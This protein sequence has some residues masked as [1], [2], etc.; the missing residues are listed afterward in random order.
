MSPFRKIFDAFARPFGARNEYG[1]RRGASRRH[2]RVA[3][4]RLGGCEQL[5]PK[6]VMAANLLAPIVVEQPL[7]SDSPVTI[8][9]ANHFGESAVTGTVV[10]FDTNAP[11][12]NPD[13]FVEL[14]DEE[15]AGRTRT[16]PL[17]VAN[18]LSYVN[19]PD[20]L[21][22]YDETIVHRA[23]PGFVI[24]GGGY[25][26]PDRAANLVGSDPVAVP[27]KPAIT[28]EPGNLN[29]RGTIAMAKLPNLPNSATNQFFFN[30]V[31]NTSLNTDNGGFTAFGRVLGS[32]MTVIDTMASALNYDAT[33]YYGNQ[34]FDDLPL[35]NVNSD[36]IVQPNDFVKFEDVSVVNETALMSFTVTSANTSKLTASIVN[37][38][39]V[40][41][42]VAGQTGTVN[43]TVTGRS[44]LDNSTASGTF[45]VALG[46]PDTLIP[47]ESV[48]NV[49]LSKGS[50]SNDIYVNG[51]T[52]VYSY[53]GQ[54]LDADA[55]AG[56]YTIERAER[57]NG[58][59]QL[60]LRF[61]DGKPWVWT[62][63][64]DWR[65]ASTPATATALGTD[66]F[67]DA[68]LAF[69]IDL[70]LDG[71][72]G[73]VVEASG[74]TVL[75]RDSGGR[76]YAAGSPVRLG[77]THITADVY[78]NYGYTIIA[79]EVIGGVN[80]LLLRHS[81]GFLWTWQMDSSW[82][83]V[84]PDPV[85]RKGMAAFFTAEST[86]GI[87]ADGDGHQGLPPLTTVEATGTVLQRDASGKLYVNG[88]G[89]LMGT[90]HITAG[91]YA[92]FGYSVVA[93]ETVS[94]VN[95]LLL[96]RG[97]DAWVWTFDTNWVQTAA[98]PVHRNGT[99]G[100]FTAERQF[101][102]DI[103]GDGDTG[104]PTLEVVESKG[105]FTLMADRAGGLYVNNTPLFMADGATRI[106]RD[107]Y[108]SY[109]YTIVAA[110]LVRTTGSTFVF[111]LLLQR[112][113]GA[114]WA[115]TMDARYR[116][117]SFGA[118][119]S[120]GSTAFFDL[121][122]LF[123]F[124]GNADGLAGRPH[125]VAGTVQLTKDS[126]DRLYVD[127]REVRVSSV[128]LTVGFYST[129][130]YTVVA[131]ER[132]GG[133]NRVLLRHTSGRLWSWTL[134]DFWVV[135]TMPATQ[136]NVGTSGFYDAEQQFG[137]DADM[138]GF[139]GLPAFFDVEANG[140]I[141]QRDDS[142]RLY[143]SG[144]RVR[145]TNGA[146]VTLDIMSSFNYTVIAAE[147][148]GSQNQLLLR[149]TNGTLWQWNFD[150]SWRFVSYGATTSPSAPQYGQVSTDFLL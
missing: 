145:Q 41:T 139:R 83:L 24:Q 47:I 77:G 114:L 146:A 125:D 143:V 16:T 92:D 131:G 64:N 5:E 140:V 135:Q 2:R 7:T 84:S 61:R 48:G 98:S 8:N 116:T 96:K 81:T 6:Q 138:D 26:A 56:S 127:G 69:T 71:A 23:V 118:V 128:P 78:A 12:A 43:V 150:S 70:D 123:G 62:M 3:A 110:D 67:Y 10:K 21:D 49:T 9:L 147:T 95:Q 68:E 76:L 97:R 100:F 11:L 119:A 117:Q 28:N 141:L 112:S 87:D 107:I 111:Q 52:L 101:G 99:E 106:T 120:R 65:T 102:V 75:S 18:F 73:R 113:N 30:L 105:T 93:A 51:G 31:N 74:Q 121:E 25:T 79:A 54:P 20:A 129:Y 88:N 1:C 17:T 90:T 37:G 40:L 148:V 15:G 39:L 108:Q 36:N 72:R 4:A 144:Q 13:F 57:V 55:F 33:T 63:T 50:V 89:V 80:H 60:L 124:D 34:A 66:A 126:Q 133:E 94:G 53:T 58:V 104:S 59:N 27:Q 132:V 38:Q 82:K 45:S 32:G 136:L 85:A 109:G 86:F 103:N 122:A 46:Q 22:N 142:S 149:H 29:A 14:F 137:F 44:A 42:P 115:W 35:W 91:V 19:D 134:N 130:G